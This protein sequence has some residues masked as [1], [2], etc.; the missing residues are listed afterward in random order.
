MLILT[1]PSAAPAV[2]QG[3]FVPYKSSLQPEG[4][5]PARGIA[6]S[7][8]R[9]L[10]KNTHCCLPKASGPCLSP[11]VAGRPLRPATDRR[12]DRILSHQPPSLPTAAPSPQALSVP[13]VH[14]RI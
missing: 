10:S 2:H 11:S 7:G 12:L 6:G 13:R 3:L 1:E 9:P 4:L 8:L 14:P 5:H